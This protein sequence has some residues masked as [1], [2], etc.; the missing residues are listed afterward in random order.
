MLELALWLKT[1]DA[2]S[3]YEGLPSKEFKV[4]KD[5]FQGKLTP[6]AAATQFTENIDM[7]PIY[8]QSFAHNMQYLLAMTWDVSD[9]RG[10][11]NI[12]KLLVAIRNLRYG[13]KKD[14]IPSVRWIC[15]GTLVS[16]VFFV[17]LINP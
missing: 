8:D 12:V 14:G 17:N 2:N 5:Y 15:D 7:E 3:F 10:Q 16:H 13:M 4:L 1:A 11:I 6:A 9:S